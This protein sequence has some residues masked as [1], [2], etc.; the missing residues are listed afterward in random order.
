MNKKVCFKYILIKKVKLSLSMSNRE[1]ESRS[2]ALVILN[3]TTK[4]K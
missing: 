4:W 1:M 3:L 2:V